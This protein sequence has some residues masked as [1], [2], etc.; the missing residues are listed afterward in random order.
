M[1]VNMSKLPKGM[2]IL[3]VPMRTSKRYGRLRNIIS[4]TP[5]VVDYINDEDMS[6]QAYR[7]V[8]VD[9]E[10]VLAIHVYKDSTVDDA[11]ML[12]VFKRLAEWC[13]VSC[14]AV[15]NT[16]TNKGSL[17]GAYSSDYGYF[18]LDYFEV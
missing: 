2:F 11:H 16:D 6:V 9:C 8:Y 15:Y 10:E 3:N 5:D 14:I 1:K 7:H 4:E 17:E 13:N 12:R 18:F